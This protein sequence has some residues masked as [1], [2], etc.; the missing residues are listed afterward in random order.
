MSLKL[1]KLREE[2][3]ETVRRWRM[4]PEVTK[5][6]Y[7]DPQI[8]SEDQRKWFEK[9]SK[10][11]SRIYWVISFDDKDVGVINL[12][13]IDMHNKRAFWAYYLGDI[14]FRGKG[15]GKNL[16]CNIYDFCFDI[17]NL[18][19]LCCEVLA[20]NEKVIV[21]HQKFGSKI[22]DVFKQHIFK[23]G[24]YYDVVRMAILKEEWNKIKHQ[25]QYE[26]IEIEQ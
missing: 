19:K 8:S 25:Y 5:Y 10:D 12:Y 21:L 1:I 3:L 13:D 4:M 24:K 6:M 15:I 20:F 26:K 18:N 22:E 9:I 23:N 7:T 2:H 14:T 17:L 16:E 11:S